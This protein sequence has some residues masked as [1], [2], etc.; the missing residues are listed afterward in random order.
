MRV[1]GY[2]RLS[3]DSDRSIAS[4][5]EAIRAECE[6][7][8]DWQLVAI[9]DDGPHSSGYREDRPAYQRMLTHVEADGADLV[10]VRDMTRFGRTMKARVY[11]ILHLE[12]LDVRVYSIDKGDVV[13]VDDPQDLLLENVDAFAD[14]VRKRAEIDKAKAELARKRRAGHPL[15]RPPFGLAYSRDKSCLV[16]AAGFETALA[17]I[18]RR[19]RGASFP[20]IARALELPQ[21]TAYRIW[22]RRARYRALAASPAD[23][24]ST[25]DHP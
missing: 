19:E 24:F 25:M 3:Q 5:A 1:V 9:F 10:M 18:K 4:Q 8:K 21:T 22:T 17:V 16:P 6:R 20:T 2:V 23:R 15:G 7:H 11:Q 12:R 14:D 13:D